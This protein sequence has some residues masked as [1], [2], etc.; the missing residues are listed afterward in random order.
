MTDAVEAKLIG[1]SSNKDGFKMIFVVQ[2][3]DVP[4]VSRMAER[5]GFVFGLAFA[6]FGRESEPRPG[7]ASNAR[8][9]V[10][11]VAVTGTS[12]D[13][14]NT[15]E[16]L[17][18]VLTEP[19]SGTEHPARVNRYTKRAGLLPNDRLFQ[20]FL[21]KKYG[22]PMSRDEAANKIRELC[23]VATRADIQP[24]TKAAVF[25]DTLESAFIGWRDFPDASS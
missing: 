25:F 22:T 15:D 18:T 12:P 17:K 8:H 14:N 10:D 21:N 3:D 19:A 6:E 16:N 9:I 23:D 11:G 24:N 4:K 13:A 7:V 2:G 1:T 5:V 20:V